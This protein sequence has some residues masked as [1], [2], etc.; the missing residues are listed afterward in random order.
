MT[1][2]WRKSQT[3]HAHQPGKTGKEVPTTL[4]F[5]GLFQEMWKR[6]LGQAVDGGE[7]L[8]DHKNSEA[9]KTRAKSDHPQQ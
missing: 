6:S 4:S 3:I 1:S 7:Q 9:E 8:I 2:I 5:W